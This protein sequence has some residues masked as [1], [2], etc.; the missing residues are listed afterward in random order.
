MGEIAE[1]KGGITEA[2][3]SVEAHPRVRRVSRI[4]RV[5]N[6]QPRA[7]SICPHIA[8]IHE[9]GLDA[10]RQSSRPPA[11]AGRHARVRRRGQCDRD[12]LG[13]A[14][15]VGSDEIEDCIHQNH[16]FR[17]RDRWTDRFDRSTWRCA[18]HA[19]SCARHR[20]GSNRT[21]NRQTNLAS[22]YTLS[23]SKVKSIPCP[24]APSAQ[25]QAKVASHV[26]SNTR[27]RPTSSRLELQRLRYAARPQQRPAPFD[28]RSRRSL[29][30]SSLRTQPNMSPASRMSPRTLV[31]R[32]PRFSRQP[33]TRV[34]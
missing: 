27:Q 30:V 6:V 29:A 20:N 25:V 16:V 12:K 1:V 11:Q 3:R 4:L 24:G 26:R 33:I 17:A 31:A 19:N 14:L 2:T 8:T 15:G 18:L 10:R 28:S 32:C 23:T 5:A 34:C 21:E 7:I 9:I 13:R 22:L